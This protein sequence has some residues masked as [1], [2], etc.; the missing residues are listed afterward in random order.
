MVRIGS[1]NIGQSAADECLGVW[2]C[3]VVGAIPLTMAARGWGK[4]CCWRDFAGAIP[5]RQSQKENRRILMAPMLFL[6][7]INGL[8]RPTVASWC[9]GKLSA[10]A[11]CR[12]R[13]CLYRPLWAIHVHLNHGLGTWTVDLRSPATT[14]A[15]RV[16]SSE[17]ADE[18]W[19][20]AIDPSGHS[21]QLSFCEW[22]I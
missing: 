12:F 8:A 2:C 21:G 17:S 10:D 19:P 6:T 22:A 4:I 9:I 3:R 11:L 15:K 5:F 14:S 20:M 13:S 1:F 7:F 18:V 16:G